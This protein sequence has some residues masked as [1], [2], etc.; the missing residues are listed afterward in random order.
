VVALRSVYVDGWT[1]PTGSHDAVK[2]Y[3][4]IWEN[5]LCSK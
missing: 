2:T 1:H 3:T 5:A 4:Y